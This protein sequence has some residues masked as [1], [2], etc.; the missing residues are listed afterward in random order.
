MTCDISFRLS[1]Y[2]RARSFKLQPSTPPITG[3]PTPMKMLL[4]LPEAL[5]S[6]TKRKFEAAKA[7]S[8][9]LFSPTELAIIRTSA[10][11]PVRVPAM[12]PTAD[13]YTTS[14]NYAIAHRLRR[15]PCRSSRML[16]RNRRSTLSRIPHQHYTWLTSPPRTQPTSSSLTSSP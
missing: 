12:P 9:L 11:I 1:R 8:D 6:I 16:R 14:S 10:G 2:L 3:T 15:N 7:S 13:L 5:S 4:G